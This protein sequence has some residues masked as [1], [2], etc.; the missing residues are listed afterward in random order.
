MRDCD[1][2]VEAG[3]PSHGL[4]G[5]A[6][7]FAAWLMSAIAPVEKGNWKWTD[8]AAGHCATPAGGPKGKMWMYSVQ[9]NR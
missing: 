6:S 1:C 3:R 8:G 5:T 7:L 2:R 4:Q 9:C